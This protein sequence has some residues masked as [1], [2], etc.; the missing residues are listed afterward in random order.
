VAQY[1]KETKD[2]LI[3]QGKDLSVRTQLSLSEEGMRQELE[4]SPFSNTE[5][6]HLKQMLT[7]L[8]VE[9]E[10]KNIIHKLVSESCKNNFAYEPMHSLD[11]QPSQSNSSSGVNISRSSNIHVGPRIELNVHVNRTGEGDL[12]LSTESDDET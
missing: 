1:Y 3:I 12:C 10:A 2:S 11:T 9:E 7:S 5:V 6:P 8:S 4:I